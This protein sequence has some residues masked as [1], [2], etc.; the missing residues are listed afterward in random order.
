MADDKLLRG[1]QDSTR[2]NINEEY[3]LNYW[4]QRF[5]VSSEILK[6]AVKEVGLSVHKIDEYL[7]DKR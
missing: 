5:N 3:E 6:E 7:N 1:P 2:V 4:T